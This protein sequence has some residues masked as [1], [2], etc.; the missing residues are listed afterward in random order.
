V[1]RR[2]SLFLVC[3]PLLGQFSYG[4]IGGI[5]FND[6]INGGLNTGTLT[7]A[8]TSG[9]Y[10]IG[11]TIQL[12]LPFGLRLEVD[13]LYRPASMNVTVPANTPNIV[14]PPKTSGSQWRVPVLLQYRLSTRLLKPFVEVGYS[15]EYAGIAPRSVTVS[16]SAG[17]L[18]TS[19]IVITAPSASRNGF[20]LGAGLDFKVPFVRLSPELRYTHQ[21]DLGSGT[22][23]TNN[24]TEFLFSI[25]F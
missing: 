23:L 4:V 21:S 5:P 14:S 15:Y 22:L 1:I 19:A 8:D 13:A 24:E 18:S 9:R 11:P 12:A 7:V 2:A 16:L 20:V 6:L 17:A 10:T 3:S 25:R